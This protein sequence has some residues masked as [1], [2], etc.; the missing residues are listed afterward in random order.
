MRTPRKLSVTGIMLLV[1]VQGLS[2]YRTAGLI[3]YSSLAA[4]IV[5]LIVQSQIS[6]GGYAAHTDVDREDLKPN[7]LLE[8]TLFDSHPDDPPILEYDRKQSRGD[9]CV[10]LKFKK[11][12]CSIFDSIGIQE[13]P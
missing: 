9:R 4:A 3:R 10:P 8:L 2:L 1:A 11:T 12:H 7:P 6:N 13:Y 5:R